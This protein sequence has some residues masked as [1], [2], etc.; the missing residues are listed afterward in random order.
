MQI[1]HG[2][3]KASGKPMAV[4]LHNL[5][6]LLHATHGDLLRLH[7]PRADL[8]HGRD[9]PDGR[10]QAPSAH[11]LDAHRARAGQRRARLRQVG[12]PAHLDRRRAGIL[13][14]R[15]FDHDHRA[16]GPDLHVLR[17]RP[18]GDAADPRRAAAARA[19]RRNAV[20]DDAGPARHRRHRRQA[21]QGRAPDAAAGIRRP[22]RRAASK[23]SSNW[24]RPPAPRCGTSTTRST[25]PTSIRCASASTRARSSIPIWWS[26]STSRTG[27]SSSP[28]STTPSAS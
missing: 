10:G 7:R 6:G 27:R 19:C 16:A 15:L 5:V 8:H 14:A 22:P 24:P 26:A 12:L 23:A 28:N 20:A 9:R 13:R 17:R 2:Y 25:S 4:I 18:A 11:R 21:A 1:A 3:A